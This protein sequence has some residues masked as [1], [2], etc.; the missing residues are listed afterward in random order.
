MGVPTGLP[1]ERAEVEIQAQTCIAEHD[2]AE[3]GGGYAGSGFY[4][5]QRDPVERDDPQSGEK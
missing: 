3:P 5:L 2:T 4:E 1:S